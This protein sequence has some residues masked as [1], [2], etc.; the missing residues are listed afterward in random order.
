[1]NADLRDELIAMD[2][3]DQAVRAE[4]AAD[5]SLFVRRVGWRA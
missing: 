1:V 2:A 3:H 5:G 4:L